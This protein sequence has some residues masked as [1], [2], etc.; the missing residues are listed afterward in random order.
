MLLYGFYVVEVLYRVN[1][2]VNEMAKTV[3]RLN[4]GFRTDIHV[5]NHTYHADEPLDAGGTDTA[6]TPT[7]MLLGALGSCMAITVKMYAERKGWPLEG[8]EVALDMERFNA[9]NYAAYAGDAQFVHE[10]RTQLVFHGPLDDAQRARLLEIAG[11]CPVHRAL[12][13]PAFFVDEL[14]SAEALPVGD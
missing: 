6:V 7:E 1:E 12:E 3:V 10:F 13:N 4:K 11:K 2:E 14:L 9:A 5:R 8:V